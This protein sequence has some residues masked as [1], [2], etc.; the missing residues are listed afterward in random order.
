MPGFDSHYLDVLSDYFIGQYLT[1][2]DYGTNQ[3]DTGRERRSV[4]HKSVFAAIKL[5]LVYRTNQLSADTQ[6]FNIHILC[7][8]QLKRACQ[9]AV[10]QIPATAG[11]V[12]RIVYAHRTVDVYLECFVQVKGITTMR[13]TDTERSD[14]RLIAALANRWCPCQISKNSS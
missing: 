2:V 3:I 6:E 1:A 4:N 5:V 14:I 12:F 7:L 8:I 13:F 10:C 9:Q 11:G